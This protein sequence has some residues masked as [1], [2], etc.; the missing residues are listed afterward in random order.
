MSERS[1]SELRPAPSKMGSAR[2]V[3]CVCVGVC[4]KKHA[5]EWKKKWK[6]IGAFQK[7]NIDIIFALGFIKIQNTSGRSLSVLSVSLSL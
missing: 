3:M 4:V 7:Q 5:I 6:K 2:V 1:T